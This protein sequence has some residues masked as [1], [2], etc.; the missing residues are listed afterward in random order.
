MD[1]QRL[2]KVGDLVN[3][4]RYR[5]YLG[6]QF[7]DI[8]KTDLAEYFKG[9]VVTIGE[10]LID[11]LAWEYRLDY[12]DT[13]IFVREDQIIPARITKQDIYK[14]LTEVDNV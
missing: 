5:A 10:V 9:K 12:N 6:E 13:S 7:T 2:F 3:L 11:T 8:P 4:I 1:I 14:A